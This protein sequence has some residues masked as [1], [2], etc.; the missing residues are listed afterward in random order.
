MMNKIVAILVAILAT[1]FIGYDI[2]KT[3]QPITRNITIPSTGVEIIAKG[4][5]IEGNIST[6]VNVEN[7]WFRPHILYILG[8]YDLKD[9]IIIKY[10]D[11]DDNEISEVRFNYS[12]FANNGGIKTARSITNIS[13]KMY[14]KIDHIYIITRAL[15]HKEL[16]R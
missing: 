7:G 13:R 15:D 4:K 5:Y 12:D 1:L 8:N 2:Y 9:F 3:S 14:R 6:T 11:S 10:V 16:V